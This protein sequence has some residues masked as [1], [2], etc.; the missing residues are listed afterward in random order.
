[1]KKYLTLI[2]IFAFSTL[3]LIVPNQAS[4]E[5][6]RGDMNM[7]TGQCREAQ[8]GIGHTDATVNEL[9]CGQTFIFSF[10]FDYPIFETDVFVRVGANFEQTAPG[11]FVPTNVIE[12]QLMLPNDDNMTF[13]ADV[14]AVLSQG[15]LFFLEAMQTN[16][17]FG[18]ET[19]APFVATMT[20]IL[21]R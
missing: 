8:L 17:V 14:S 1:M 10:T 16:G 3:G 9:G 12:N 19:T 2:A 21:I 18:N 15:G 4:A 11:L 6:R 13:T 20:G 5:G 7:S